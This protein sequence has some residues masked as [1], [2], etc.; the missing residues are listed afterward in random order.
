MV[1][2]TLQTLNVNARYYRLYHVKL[3]KEIQN[4]FKKTDNL[5]DVVHHITDTGQCSRDI[6]KLNAMLFGTTKSLY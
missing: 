1:D 6:R 4:L 5:G 3:Y 2:D